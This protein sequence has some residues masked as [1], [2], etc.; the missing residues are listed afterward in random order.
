[1]IKLFSPSLFSLQTLL[2]LSNTWPPFSLAVANE[3]CM[4]PEAFSSVPDQGTLRSVSEVHCDFSNRDLPST[5]G[6]LPRAIA[7]WRYVWGVSWTTLTNSS[8][9]GFLCLIFGFC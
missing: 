1:M 5:P 7:I 9:E 2:D 3:V 8:R 6:R 4:V